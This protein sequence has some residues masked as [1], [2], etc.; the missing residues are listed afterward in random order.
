[1]VDRLGAG[2][3]AQL[4]VMAMAI[5][6]A[7]IAGF[8]PRLG[9]PAYIGGIAILTPGYQLF[10]AANTTLVLTKAGAAERGAISG[11]LGL[12]RN[13]GLII[14]AAGL[15]A[16]FARATGRAD[17]AL[18]DAAQIGIAVAISFAVATGLLIAAVLLVRPAR[19]Q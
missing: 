9:L 17:A 8:S 6:V 14:G 16:L 12:S 5:A 19:N 4:G 15:G 2:R 3:V 18:A 7:L 1:M 10:L 13:I 11:L